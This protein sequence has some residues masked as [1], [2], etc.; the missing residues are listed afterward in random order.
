MSRLSWRT[1]VP[2]GGV[3]TC[4]LQVQDLH[5]DVSSAALEIYAA[6]VALS[7]FLHLSYVSDEMGWCINLPVEIHVDNAGSRKPGRN[8]ELLALAGEFLQFYGSGG[9]SDRSGRC[10][11]AMGCSGQRDARYKPL[12]EGT[13]HINP[14]QVR[15]ASAHCIVSSSQLLR[16]HNHKH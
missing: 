2:L 5:A 8:Q 9:Y 1:E 3:P 16:N 11:D 13:A 15:R 10:R 12:S 6:S 7:E 14:K 4:H